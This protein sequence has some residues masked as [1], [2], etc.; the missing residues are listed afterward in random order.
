MMGFSS[1]FQER[2]LDPVQISIRLC[3][4]KQILASSLNTGKLLYFK[5]FKAMKRPRYAAKTTMVFGLSNQL[6]LEKKSHN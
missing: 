5:I 4:L 6:N 2:F 3:Y 1:H